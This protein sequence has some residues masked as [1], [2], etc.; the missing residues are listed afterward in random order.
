MWNLSPV[1]VL[2]SGKWLDLRPVMS[3]AKDRSSIVNQ[4]DLDAAQESK[5]LLKEEKDE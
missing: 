2:S 5:R 3:W 1:R 4:S